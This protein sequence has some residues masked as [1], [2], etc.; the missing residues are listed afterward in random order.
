MGVVARFAAADLNAQ[1]YNVWVDAPTRSR[2][3]SRI[4]ARFPV[5]DGLTTC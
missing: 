1:S 2:T 4:T 5:Y 3:R